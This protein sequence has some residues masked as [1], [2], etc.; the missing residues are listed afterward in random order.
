MWPSKKP[1]ELFFS[2]QKI[3]YSKW[4]SGLPVPRWGYGEINKCL[5]KS[6]ESE[7]DYWNLALVSFGLYDVKGILFREIIH[8]L[9]TDCPLFLQWSTYF[10]DIMWIILSC[11]KNETLIEIATSLENLW[12]RTAS[13][14]ILSNTHWCSFPTESVCLEVAESVAGRVVLLQLLSIHV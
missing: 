14:L 9:C 4:T 8:K 10:L 5:V 11:I 12:Q 2:M 3:F 7:S 13:Y 6:I 1:R